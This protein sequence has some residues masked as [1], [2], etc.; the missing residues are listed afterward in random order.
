VKVVLLLVYSVLTTWK[1]GANSRTIVGERFT[2][3][4]GRGI[5]GIASWPCRAQVSLFPV[6]FTFTESRC[7]GSSYIY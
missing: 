7:H 4:A 1:G 5:D 6:T 3:T 2:V